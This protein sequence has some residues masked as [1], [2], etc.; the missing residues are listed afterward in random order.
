MQQYCTDQLFCEVEDHPLAA[1]LE[2]EDLFHRNGRQTG[3]PGDAIAH[4]NHD[5]LLGYTQA[6]VVMIKPGSLLFQ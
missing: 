5:T 2:C 4:G 6:R 3:N 1:I